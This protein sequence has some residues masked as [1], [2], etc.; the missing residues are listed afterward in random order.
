MKKFKRS[1]VCPVCGRVYSTVKAQTCGRAK[2]AETMTE[3]N[4]AVPGKKTAPAVQLP[5]L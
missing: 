1:V 4:K 3:W 5:L 2:C